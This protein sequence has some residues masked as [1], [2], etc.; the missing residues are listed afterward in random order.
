MRTYVTVVKAPVE[1]LQKM[2]DLASWYESVKKVAERMGIEIVGG[3]GLLG[4]Y[5][6]MFIYHAPNDKAAMSL[7]F[8]GQPKPGVTSETWT[9]VPMEEFASIINRAKE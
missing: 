7:S 6:M 3:Y 4:R 1:A 8:A 5:D 9:A 2:G